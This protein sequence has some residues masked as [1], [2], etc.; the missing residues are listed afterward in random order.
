MGITCQIEETEVAGYDTTTT[1]LTK[2]NV[3]IAAG[4][5]SVTFT[6]DC[7]LAPPTGLEGDTGAYQLMLSMAGLAV[8]AAGAG[9]IMMRRRKRR[10][11]E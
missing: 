8:M 10:E 5:Q 1:G 9:W 7:T 6:N 2:G 4:T 11:E 3:T